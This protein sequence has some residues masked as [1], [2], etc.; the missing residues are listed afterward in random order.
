[1]NKGQSTILLDERWKLEDF[2]ILTKEY[3]QLYGFFHALRAIDEGKFS[4]LEFERMPWL[5]GEALLA[6]S[7]S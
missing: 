4:N 7:A 3:Q 2:T 6:F 1:M 5:G